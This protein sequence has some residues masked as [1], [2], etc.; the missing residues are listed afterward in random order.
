MEPDATSPRALRSMCENILHLVTTTVDVMEGV[1]GSTINP[2][3]YQ[4]LPR[5]GVDSI[6][7]MFLLLA[8]F[9]RHPPLPPA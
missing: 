4:I 2:A 1:S 8:A 6:P 7:V 9:K 3:H 5:Y